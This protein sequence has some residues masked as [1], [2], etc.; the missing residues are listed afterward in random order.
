MVTSMVTTMMTNYHGDIYLNI[1]F[2]GG[3]SQI[4][5]RLFFSPACFAKLSNLSTERQRKSKMC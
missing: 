1:H 4:T 2:K 3:D 5:G